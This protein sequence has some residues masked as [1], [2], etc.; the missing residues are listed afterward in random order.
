MGRI[1]EIPKVEDLLREISSD[2]ERIIRG[3]LELIS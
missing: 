1:N 2:A 3:L